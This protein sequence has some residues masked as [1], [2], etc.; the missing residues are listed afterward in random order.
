[1]R[2][3]RR[4]FSC[5]LSQHSPHPAFPGT[6]LA[7]Y[8]NYTG[9]VAVYGTIVRFYYTVRRLLLAARQRVLTRRLRS[10]PTAA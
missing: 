9:G 10:S 4:R 6:G 1:M 8:A 2:V 7:A 5:V 3:R